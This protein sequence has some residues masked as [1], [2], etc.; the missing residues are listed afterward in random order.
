[1]WTGDQRESVTSNPYSSESS[2]TGS[3]AAGAAAAPLGIWQSIWA[4]GD[5]RRASPASSGSARAF[6]HH[7][8]LRGFA[9]FALGSGGGWVPPKFLFGGVGL[10]FCTIAFGAIIG[11]ALGLIPALIRA[12]T[13]RRPAQPS[14]IE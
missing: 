7:S 1:M 12:A 5:E 10:I 11:A 9:A 4:R 13:G 2:P 14:P 8:R 3:A 6:V